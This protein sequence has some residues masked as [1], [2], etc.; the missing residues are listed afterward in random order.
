MVSL[1]PTAFLYMISIFLN[2]KDFFYLLTVSLVYMYVLDI[3]E[4]T[5][6]DHCSQACLNIPGSYMCRCYD[7]F[8]L[9]NDN[10]TCVGML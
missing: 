4:C 10:A 6:G 3:N 8:Q 7:G 5:E 2:A 9:S 1:V